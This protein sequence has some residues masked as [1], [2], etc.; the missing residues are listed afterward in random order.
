[1]VDTT[2]KQSVKGK[3]IEKKILQLSSK[4]IGQLVFEDEEGIRGKIVF[5]RLGY[6][7][8]MLQIDQRYIIIGKP[9]IK[10]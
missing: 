7:F 1:M 10:K 4:K 9:Q 2:T 8:N 6:G 3:I 5:F